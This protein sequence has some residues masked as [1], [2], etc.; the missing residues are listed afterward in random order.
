[1][2]IISSNR[3]VAVFIIGIILSGMWSCAMKPVALYENTSSSD[4][5]QHIENVYAL[6]IF[7]DY[8][9]SEIW[10]TEDTSCLQVENVFDE[11][12]IGKGALH[13]KWN[14]TSGGC[15]WIGMGI[16][17][18]GWNPKNLQEIYPNASIEFNVRSPK[19]IQNGLPWAMALEDYSGGQAWA[20]V[21]A[22]YIEGI[23]FFTLPLCFKWWR[24]T[25]SNRPGMVSSRSRRNQ[26]IPQ[27]IV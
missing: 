8:L 24:I 3:L 21:F 23:Y 4:S 1:M 7:K 15:I 2:I 27:Q 11:K 10:F 14:K 16:G 25:E 22:N 20:G 17:W 18:D 12:A 26:R 13:L 5:V 9:S 6:Q 19:G